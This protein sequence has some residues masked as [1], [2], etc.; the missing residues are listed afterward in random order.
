MLKVILTGVVTGVPDELVNLP[1]KFICLFTGYAENENN[2]RSDA[3]ININFFINDRSR[4]PS[5]FLV[6]WGNS[7]IKWAKIQGVFFAPPGSVISRNLLPCLF[8]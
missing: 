7:N 1:W 2:I 5:V 3:R 4:E 6:I 8:A